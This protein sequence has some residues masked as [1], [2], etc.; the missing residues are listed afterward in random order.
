MFLTC[1]EA[2]T[3]PHIFKCKTGQRERKL[4]LYTQHTSAIHSFGLEAQHCPWERLVFPVGPV[5]A[6]HVCGCVHANRWSAAFFTWRHIRLSFTTRRNMQRSVGSL[7]NSFFSVARTNKHISMLIPSALIYC[8]SKCNVCKN[9]SGFVRRFQ[10]RDQLKHL[11]SL[12]FN[13]IDI[14]KKAAILKDTWISLL[15][16]S[17]RSSRCPCTPSGGDCVA[18]STK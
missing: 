6:C 5:H 15:T 16:V 18:M 4:W 13:H 14:Y 11:G 7:A 9:L 2:Y 3:L 10:R 17:S 12:I 1:T 8:L